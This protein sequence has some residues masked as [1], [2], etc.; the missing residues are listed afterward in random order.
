MHAHQSGDQNRQI[1]LADDRLQKGEGAGGSGYGR[2]VPVTQCGLGDKTVVHEIDNICSQ[3]LSDSKRARLKT[4]QDSENKSPHQSNEEVDTGRTHDEV[5]GNLLFP[6]DVRED[7]DHYI[8]IEKDKETISYHIERRTLHKVSRPEHHKGR[9]GNEQGDDEVI[10]LLADR[11]YSR[12]QDKREE[13]IKEEAD[14]DVSFKKRTKDKQ[15]QYGNEQEEKS[16]QMD[17]REGN[18]PFFGHIDSPRGSEPSCDQFIPL[19]VR[20][21][22]SSALLPI[23]PP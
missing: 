6:E 21:P 23:G 13:N 22:S 16:S 12:K 11:V 20:C 18:T 9:E 8:G 15:E 4:L 3:T 14:S 17:L 19:T 2:D 10:L 1:E 7:D 5:G